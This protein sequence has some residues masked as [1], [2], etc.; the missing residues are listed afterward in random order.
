MFNTA[1]RIVG[2]EDSAYDV[3]QDTF[4]QV[5]NSLHQ[6]QFR[7]TLGAWI[8]TILIREALRKKKQLKFESGQNGSYHEPV[9]WPDDLSGDYLEKAIMDLPDGYRMVFTLIEIEGYTHKEVGK[10]LRISEGTSKSQLYYAKKN[11][12]KRLVDFNKSDKL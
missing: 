11:L 5:F 10:M 4:I 7:S 9:I 3:V 2:E 6:F 1:L 12:Q 8:K